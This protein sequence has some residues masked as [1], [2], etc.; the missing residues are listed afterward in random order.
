MDTQEIKLL[1]AGIKEN[2]S[3]ADAV[4]FKVPQA[5]LLSPLYLAGSSGPDGFKENLLIDGGI[6]AMDPTIFLRDCAR[7]KKL[8][9]NA[10]ILKLLLWVQENA[11]FL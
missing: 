5:L 6:Y 9:P 3:T 1:K 11:S 2:F 7:N 4:F 10:K 8:F